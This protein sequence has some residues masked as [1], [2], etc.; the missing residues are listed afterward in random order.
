MCIHALPVLTSN[1]QTLPYV[2]VQLHGRSW[3]FPWTRSGAR[4][5]SSPRTIH[6]FPWGQR[7]ICQPPICRWRNLS[8]SVCWREAT[9]TYGSW[10][11]CWMGLDGTSMVKMGIKIHCD[12]L[13]VLLQM[14]GRRL[15]QILSLKSFYPCGNF[16]TVRYRSNCITL[17]ALLYTGDKTQT[18]KKHTNEIYIGILFFFCSCSERWADEPMHPCT[19][20]VRHERRCALCGHQ[21][22]AHH[23]HHRASLP[24]GEG[25]LLCWGTRESSHF[26]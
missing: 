5:L 16:G 26:K 17:S 1:V 20:Q 3:S 8:R 6:R 25:I 23:S 18:V 22:G 4:S 14:G 19:S 12:P 7:L 24:S 9:P 13:T 2:Y 11:T 15:F 21:G 10:R